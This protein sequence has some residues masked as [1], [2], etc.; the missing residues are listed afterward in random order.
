MIANFLQTPMGNLTLILLHD[1]LFNVLRQRV[2]FDSPMVFEHQ[3]ATLRTIWHIPIQI[4]LL[5][6]L[7]WSHIKRFPLS[8][9]DIC[10]STIASSSREL[11]TLQSL[12]LTRFIHKDFFIGLS[13]TI[14]LLNLLL[15]D[16]RLIIVDYV[17]ELVFAKL[18]RILSRHVLILF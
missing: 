3:I 2:I 8:K 12:G 10:D 18:T 6:N 1:H 9:V 16:S 11:T 5:E 17:D 14:R 13:S 4:V 7:D 15:L